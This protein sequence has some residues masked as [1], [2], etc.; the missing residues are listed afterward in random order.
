MAEKQNPQ[1]PMWVLPLYAIGGIVALALIVQF[2]AADMSGSQKYF[3][4]QVISGA[5]GGFIYT[6]RFRGEVKPSDMVV[7]A[8]ILF[9]I[10]GAMF[11]LVLGGLT[12]WAFG[13]SG[14][15][16][17]LLGLVSLVAPLWMAT[18]AH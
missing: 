18:T 17:I 11:G 1:V 3:L 13:L 6:Y 10:I 5:A 7:F 16:G 14:V 12:L 8:L 4:F 9:T 15:L 2:F